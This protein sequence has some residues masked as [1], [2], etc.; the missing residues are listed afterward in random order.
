MSDILEELT[1]NYY[2]NGVQL[3]KQIGA[4]VLS[5]TGIWA[6]IAYLY[7]D[8]DTIGWKPAKVTIV[9]Y[10]KVNG[11]WKKDNHLNINS[12]QRA[13]QIISVLTEWRNEIGSKEE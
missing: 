9:R 11:L 3:R 12:P 8:Q 1:Y 4:V 10:K 2:K 7:Q 5:N 13:D 6:D